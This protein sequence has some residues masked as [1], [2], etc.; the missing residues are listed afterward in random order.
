[1]KINF[2]SLKRRN[3]EIGKNDK[4]RPTQS[5][6][7]SII[8]NL[9]KINNED[10]VLD[11]FAGTGALGFEAVSLGAKKVYWIDNNHESFK[12]IKKNIEN[13]D[14]SFENFKVFKTDFRR[15]ITKIDFKPSII[16]LD[17]PFIATKYYDEA[18]KIINKH[19]VMSNNGVIILE[20]QHKTIIHELVNYE[21]HDQ[22]KLG[23]KDILILKYKS[24]NGSNNNN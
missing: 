17:P 10:L 19:N 4:M 5:M 1:M 11:L 6:A 20:K 13:F 23:E 15:A 16:F 22:R 8:F 3:L 2:G 7:K 24:K 14:L 12:A 21:I 9:I 18:L